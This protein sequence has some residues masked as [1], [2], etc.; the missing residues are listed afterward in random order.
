MYLQTFMLCLRLHSFALLRLCIS[1]YA[2]YLTLLQV[3]V[4]FKHD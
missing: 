3:A 2:L 4:L 1:T